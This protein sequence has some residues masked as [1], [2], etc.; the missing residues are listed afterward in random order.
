MRRP[1]G[2]YRALSAFPFQFYQNDELLSAATERLLAPFK[3]DSDGEYYGGWRGDWN[4]E[5][6]GRTA[7]NSWSGKPGGETEFEFV[8]ESP[9]LPAR[10]FIEFGSNIGG[11]GGSGEL[12]FS[13]TLEIGNGE[14]SRAFSFVSGQTLSQVA[15]SINFL[16]NETGVMAIASGTG[17]RL[18]STEYG[19]GSFVSVKVLDPGNADAAEVDVYEVNR[20]YGRDNLRAI[21][22]WATEDD[23]LN[24]GNDVRGRLNGA[25]GRSI[26]D[27]TYFEFG[28]SGYAL[29]LQ[30][31]QS[32]FLGSSYGER[33]GFGS[34]TASDDPGGVRTP[35]GPATGER[36]PV[37]R[38]DVEV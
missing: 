37:R 6:I 29:A 35:E 18:L 27:Y 3:P 24:A 38:L 21:G 28:S 1:Y 32:A 5:L 36:A 22:S 34:L 7:F 2:L 9:P 26:G 10:Q 13:T 15:E 11:E 20:L 19:S 16:R 31:D 12:G 4:G 23:F 25:S 17:L 8:L 14:L 33:F 30:L